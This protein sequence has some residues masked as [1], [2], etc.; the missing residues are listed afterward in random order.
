MSNTDALSKGQVVAWL[1][2]RGANALRIARSK[3][4]YDR[5]EWLSDADYFNTAAAAL[6]EK[7]APPPWSGMPE[8]PYL[9]ANSGHQAQA[10]RGGEE[11]RVAPSDATDAMLDAVGPIDWRMDERSVYRLIYRRMLAAAPRIEPTRKTSA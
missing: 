1:K 2:E 9:K 8:E 5:K 4:V 10:L 6:A 3:D 7:E 11:P